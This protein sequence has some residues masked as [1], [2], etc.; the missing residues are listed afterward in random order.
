MR[1]IPT[2]SILLVAAA[3]VPCSAA[4]VP[5]GAAL[6]QTAVRRVTM[7]EA[8]QAFGSGSLA[9]RIA[10]AEGVEAAALARQYRSY[11]NP[12]FSLVHES[13]GSSNDVYRET[14]AGVAQQLEWPR[15][16][17][18]RARVAAHTI[19]G[20]TAR[21]RADSVRLAFELRKAYVTAWLAEKTEET[22]R[23]AADVM[24]VV[25]EGV[26][27]RLEMGDISRYEARRLR[28]E[29][30]RAE[31]E[32]SEAALDARA[33]RRLLAVLITPEDG[34]QEVGPAAEVGGMPPGI[35][36]ESALAALGGRPDL[37]AAEHD[38]DAAKAR[39][40]VAMDA[41]VPDPTLSLGY[42][43]Q[44]DGF[45]GAALSVDLPM[46]VFDRGAGTQQGAIA[47][48]TASAHTLTLTRRLAEIDL[49]GASDRYATHRGHLEATGDEL[50]S[51]ADY[52]LSAART[53]YS[54]G[55]IG[56]TEL[57]DATA[58]YR[59]TR[60]DALSLRAATWIAYYDLLR[61]M[62]RAP[63]EES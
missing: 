25:A 46:P 9:L 48:E 5:G 20:A 38:L 8:M 16:T 33:A 56:Q 35:A 14:T 34:V 12:A 60:I 45:S 29:A 50:L 26:E 42:K 17:A 59:D 54:E 40:R 51:H 28:L 4:L 31:R 22:R 19:D 47:R 24:R 36:A 61:A 30:A 63:D 3:L 13:L 41:W 1:A 21:F 43:N 39:Y 10:R 11:A 49:L 53:A 57:L 6:A 2:S 44:R 18:S 55:H 27:R 23:E 58:T 52:V 62:A 37:E 15:R 7:A 32:V